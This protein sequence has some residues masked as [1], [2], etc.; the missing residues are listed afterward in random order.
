MFWIGTSGYN[1]LEWRGS[2][3]PPKLAAARMLAFY[4]A[5]F[6][7][8]EI[9]ATFYRMPT[10]PMLARW[11]AATPEN[12]RFTLKAPRRITH[13]AKLQ[14]CR[15]LVESLARVASGLRAKLGV[16]LFQMPPTF[17]LALPVLEEFLTWLPAGL[18]VAVEFRHASW[19]VPEVYECL[20]SHNS[21]LCVAESQ[22]LETPLVTTA[23][24]GYFRLRDE[25][26]APEDL[27]RL[28]ARLRDVQ[29]RCG[30]IFVYFK[31]E[32]AGKGPEFARQLMREL[33]LEPESPI[34]DS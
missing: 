12:F 22:K 19:F 14:G 16:L 21:A 28:A 30:E 24:F 9:N 20:R 2:F 3:Y 11:A 5:R 8:V 17:R 7:T 23:D 26:Y 34:P 10:S 32:E 18:R 6:P 15:P 1:Y 25:G 4:A 13:D 27:R 33:G 31:H 29:Q